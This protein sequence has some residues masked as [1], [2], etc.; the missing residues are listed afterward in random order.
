VEERKHNRKKEENTIL[1]ALWENRQGEAIDALF[2]KRHLP[3]EW[4]WRVIKIL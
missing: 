3:L 2:R 4:L 1:F